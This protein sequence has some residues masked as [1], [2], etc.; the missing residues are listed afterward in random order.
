MFNNL[1]FL[2]PGYWAG[3]FLPTSDGD[4][5]GSPLSSLMVDP[6]FFSPPIVEMNAKSIFF[7]R[8]LV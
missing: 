4:M 6:L 5:M 1:W 7:Q 3:S 8:E 2:S